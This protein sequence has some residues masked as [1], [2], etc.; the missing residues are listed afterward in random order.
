MAGYPDMNDEWW[1]EAVWPDY[2]LSAYQ[3]VPLVEE[4]TP[5]G[6]PSRNVSITAAC[7]TNNFNHKETDGEEAAPSV[8]RHSAFPSQR[9]IS[10]SYSILMVHYHARLTPPSFPSAPPHD[11]RKCTQV[12]PSARAPRRS[13]GRN[14]LPLGPPRSSFEVLEG[15]LAKTIRFSGLC[16]LYADRVAVFTV[17][18]IENK[19]R[20]FG[21]VTDIP[22]SGR[23]R[24]LDDER[25]LDILLYIQ[26]NPHK[27]TRQ[28]AADNDVS[29]TSIL[30][31]PK[32]E[33]YRPYKIHLVPELND[34]DPDRRL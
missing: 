6:F 34:D 17:S 31:L 25:E 29:K 23:K 7:I 10:T 21:N 4:F 11:M 20:E 8:L 16:P 13:G 12:P 2:L 26:D 9:K 22:K 33:K 19:F 32:N 27:P 24:I 15:D 3:R 5:N 18:R 30:R 14:R 28:V 1:A